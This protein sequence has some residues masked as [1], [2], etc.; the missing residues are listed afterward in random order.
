MERHRGRCLHHKTKCRLSV[1]RDALP[2]MEFFDRSS[3]RRLNSSHRKEKCRNVGARRSSSLRHNSFLSGLPRFSFS[4]FMSIATTV[5]AAKIY[6]F[7]GFHPGEPFQSV[8]TDNKW[9]RYKL[10]AITK[11]VAEGYSF[12]FGMKNLHSSRWSVVFLIPRPEH[13]SFATTRLSGVKQLIQPHCLW[14]HE[15]KKKAPTDMK[16]TR[17]H[18]DNRSRQARQSSYL[19]R[20]SKAVK[21]VA[22]IIGAVIG[23]A[24]WAIAKPI[25]RGI[26]WLISILSAIGA[27]YWLLTL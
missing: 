9:V 17:K 3:T 16:A 13:P 5:G 23:I 1:F 22:I 15:V 24:L 19:Y 27:I 7:M 4:V 12:G 11:R 6:V 14:T 25:L 10:L 20:I 21:A 8:R 18:K 2:C 26:G